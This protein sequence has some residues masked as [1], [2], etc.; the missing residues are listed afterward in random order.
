MP[1]QKVILI[2]WKTSK[3][4]KLKLR[5][6]F[7]AP[8]QIAAYVGALNHDP[9]YP[10]QIEN[11]MIAVVYNDGS[12]A[13]LIHMDK[14]ELIRHWIMWLNRLKQYEK[15]VEQRFIFRAYGSQA[16]RGGHC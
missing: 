6:T 16:F 15:L 4:Q 11:A 7:D 8:I 9:R 2:D 1:S 5:H 10:F 13:N 3:K 12:E 14:K